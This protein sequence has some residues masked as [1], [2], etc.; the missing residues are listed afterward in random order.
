MPGWP[1]CPFLSGHSLCFHFSDTLG[2][3]LT[4]LFS[5]MP[6]ARWESEEQLGGEQSLF[7][8]PFCVWGGQVRWRERQ[9]LPD[10]FVM[11]EFML[12]SITPQ[13]TNL[14]VWWRAHPGRRGHQS[15]LWTDC[16]GS[17]HPGNVLADSHWG[18][19]RGQFLWIKDTAGCYSSMTFPV[20]IMAQIS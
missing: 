1:F 14:S 16:L 5:H 18:V 2:V 9:E 11:W 7:L 12:F 13:P 4:R 17:C 10:A 19:S 15:L 3:S 8:W 20:P 6:W